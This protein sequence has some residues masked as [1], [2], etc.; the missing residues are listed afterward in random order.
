MINE[1]SKVI[2]STKEL[3][4][5]YEENVLTAVYKWTPLKYTEYLEDEVK[6]KSALLKGNYDA[7]L[8][9]SKTIDSFL[10]WLEEQRGEFM[11]D[12]G[13]ATLMTIIC[14]AQEKLSPLQFKNTEG[15]KP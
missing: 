6:L 4:E 2:K 7:L 14:E 15:K 10:K 11:D 3:H 1:N 9:L 13:E 5:M 8:G 12:S